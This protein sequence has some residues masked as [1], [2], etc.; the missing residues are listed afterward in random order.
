M[1]SNCNDKINWLVMEIS[2]SS[3]IRPLRTSSFRI[4][5]QNFMSSATD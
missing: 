4:A 1:L 3:A 2:V 5:S